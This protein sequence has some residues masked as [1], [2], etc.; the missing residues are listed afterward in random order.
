MKHQTPR[1]RL[2]S[3]AR[4][5]LITCSASASIFAMQAA[6]AQDTS[7]GSTQLER[8]EITGSSI[9]RIA[10]EAALP[11][12]TFS[13][14][15]IK[16]SGVTSVT[17]FIQQLP[18]M[19]GF[20]VA[21][22]SVGG[23][24]G[25]IT[26]AS[27]HDIGETYTL[28]LLNG[29][30]M[31]PATSG[32]TIDIN[33]I[34]LAAV[35]RI[36]VLTD[37]ASALYGSDAIA[38]VVNFILKKGAAP[39]TIE[40]KVGKPQHPGAASRMVS[41]SKGFGDFDTDGY[42]FFV[43]GSHQNEDR[44]KASQRDFAKTGII[45]FTNPANGELLHFFNGSSRSIPPNVAVSY[46]DANG[47]K[48]SVNINP[49]LK[50]NG[51]CPAAHVD[52]GDGNCYFDYTSS[53]E[54]APEIKRDSI[55]AS[56]SI[57]L[58]NSGFKAFG[59]LALNNAHVYSTIAPYPAEFALAKTSPLFT[60]YIAPYLTPLQL[61]N[62]TS[63]NVKYRLQDLGGR[64]YDYQSQTS[65]VV[66]GVDGSA[67]GWDVNSAVT[68][69]E[70]KQ[71]QNYVSGFPLADRF[72]TALSNGSIDP[73]PYA[74]GEMPATMITA[75]KDTQFTG[76]YNTTDIKMH[77]IDGRASREVFK[78]GGGSA[79]LGI[80]ADYRQTSYTQRA[81]QAV[82]HAEILFDD[83]Q[84]EFDL[85]RS[86]AGA[87]AE[88]LMP[89]SKQIEIT[90]SAR[91]DSISKITDGLNGVTTGNDQ[92][93]GTYKV[94]ARYQ[95]QKS[96]LFRAAFGTGFKAGSM[97]EIAQPKTDFGVTGGTYVCPFTAANG[98][99]NHPLAQYCDSAKGQIEEFTGGNPELKPE[100]S[101]QWSLGAVFEPTDNI[102]IKLD[103][104]NVSI[105]DAITSVDEALILA[106]PNKYIGLY[107]TKYKASTGLST[108][109]ILLAPINIGQQENRGL[110]Y[111]FVFRNK[112]GN[113]KMTNRIAGTYMITSRYTTPGTSDSWETSLGQYGSNSAVTFRNVIKA[114]STV[115]YGSWT[116]TLAANYRSGYKDKHHDVDNCAVDNG[117]DCVDVQLNVPEYYTFD[118]QTQFR[119]MKNLELTAGIVNLADKKPPLSLRNTGSHQLGYDPRYAS[120]V[121]RTYYLSASYKF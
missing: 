47:K 46:L 27:I 22:D 6:L 45:D 82:A 70:N 40:A 86:N 19:Q 24:G 114:S 105:K 8:V 59:D 13:Q 28:V 4:L 61:A 57:K 106:D 84:P 121:G 110:D 88:L 103:L 15:D 53:V 95:P 80:G 48:K 26:T 77:G 2:N 35:E 43:S 67:M 38:G 41:L 54:I 118:W 115:D 49:Y 64:A 50:I 62:E 98:L 109:A 78:L 17:D 16:R 5:A 39:F 75:L 37:G 107:T 60:Q 55:F 29:R 20:T 52:L 73:F 9:K 3:V 65:H 97:M 96:M 18:V 108:L 11:V 100:T 66:A 31:A 112:L 32:S 83:P 87:Y 76:T 104:W 99:Q 69:S 120:P 10:A 44:L 36:E 89:F 72:T 85:K 81:N 93:A 117:V 116:H 94:S 1:F 14:A 42:S 23:G 33:S 63:A 21:A 102:S 71:S 91:Y 79:Q 90:T 51:K 58:G 92:S 7:T 101:R 56:G 25:G 111:D 12:Q 113:G 30:R 68:I 74:L 119:P 34:P